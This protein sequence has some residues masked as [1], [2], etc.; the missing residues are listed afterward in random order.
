MHR[1]YLDG[2]GQSPGPAYPGKRPKT[3]NAF[4]AKEGEETDEESIEETSAMSTGAVHGSG[5]G[6]V[7]DDDDNEKTEA[8]TEEDELVEEIMNYL[9]GQSG[10]K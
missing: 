1:A 3:S 8:L 7:K 6:T 10:V 9:L 5:R 4:L 2:G